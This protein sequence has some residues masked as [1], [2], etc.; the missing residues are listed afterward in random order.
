MR[1]W[2]ITD[3]NKNSTNIEIDE[4]IEHKTTNDL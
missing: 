3:D 1:I 4:L 2:S